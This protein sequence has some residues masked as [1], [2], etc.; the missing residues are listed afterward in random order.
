MPIIAVVGSKG[1][2]KT[3]TVEVLVRELTKKG[4]KVATVKHIP[5]ENFTIDTEGKDTWRH[6]KA[7]AKMIIS[8]APREIAVIHKVEIGKLSL[9][10]ILQFC[11]GNIDIVV[12]EGFR[13]LV[14]ADPQNLQNSNH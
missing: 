14:G 7:G 2:G 5:E 10:N 13:N 12:L 8:V 4:Y 3:S 11:E 6:A 9:E 1:S